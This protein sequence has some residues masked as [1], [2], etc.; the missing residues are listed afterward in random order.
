[1]GVEEGKI[2][3]FSFE[4]NQKSYKSFTQYLKTTST[5]F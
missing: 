1:M 4:T 3:F 5:K 2:I